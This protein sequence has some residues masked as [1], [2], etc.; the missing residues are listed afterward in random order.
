MA[1]DNNND[2]QLNLEEIVEI[3]PDDLSDGQKTFL[4]TKVDD[5]TD[6]QVETFGLKRPPPPPV[7]PEVRNKPPAKK[8]KGDEPPVK[9]GEEIDPEDAA[10]IGKV[11]AEAIKP[12]QEQIGRQTEGLQANT[13][14][15][16][17]DGLIREKPEFEPYR[18]QI[19]AY[20]KHPSYSNVTALNIAKIV[21]G[22]DLM[23]LGAQKEREAAGEVAKTK[24]AG[25]TARRSEGGGKDW[26][27]VSKEEFEAK[28]TEVMGRRA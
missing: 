5:L 4:E 13:D 14:A 16:E 8:P 20:M 15:K 11:V 18:G 22:D 24:G 25:G 3:A 7:E 23:K 1:E 21:A 19:L 12:L 28:R 9:P 17:V 26:S 2:P 6:E 10:T 27:K